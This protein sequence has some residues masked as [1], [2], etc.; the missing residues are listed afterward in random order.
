MAD[1]IYTRGIPEWAAIDD[2]NYKMLL[3]G[4]TYVAD[5]D[6]DYVDDVSSD[7]L[8]DASYARQTISG[9]NVT[10]DDTNDRVTYDCT[11]V[12]WTALAG[13]EAIG[14]V[15]LYHEINDDTDSILMAYY[16]VSGTSNGDDMIFV[17]GSSGLA[18]FYQP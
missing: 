11:D 1:V 9:S 18:Y 10:Y 6:H 4:T 14:G 16:D 7:E 3:V 8:T 13:G 2:T 12:T 17:V 5:K 15:I